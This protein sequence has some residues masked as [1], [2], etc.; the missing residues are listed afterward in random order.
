M[1]QAFIPAAREAMISQDNLVR[2][3]LKKAN[4][5]AAAASVN[6]LTLPLNVECLDPTVE[7]S[8]MVQTAE[9]KDDASFGQNCKS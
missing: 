4:G 1:A 2:P 9:P 8:F 5:S 3:Y 7:R 6:V